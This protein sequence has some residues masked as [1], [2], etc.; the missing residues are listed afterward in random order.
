MSRTQPST[1]AGTP[2]ASDGA[3][4]EQGTGE[5]VKQAAEQ[6]SELVR[7]EL[8]LAVAEVKDK[9]RHAGVGAGLF[10]GAGLVAAYGMG[11][12]VTAVIAGLAVA[13]PV[14]AAALIV[15]VV[16]LAVAGVLAVMG[17]KETTRAAPP[18]PE[19]AI[20]GARRDVAEVKERARR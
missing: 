5:L 9:G 8:R 11:A 7:A 15:A 6:I 17:R 2:T 14:W 4:P 13:L 12:L 16:L 3:R 20:A 19:Q 10:G 18:T 1:S